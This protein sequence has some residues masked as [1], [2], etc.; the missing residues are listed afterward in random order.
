MLSFKTK[1]QSLH[2]GIQLGKRV[3]SNSMFFGLGPSLTEEQKELVQ[4]LLDPEVNVVVIPSVAG[5]GKTTLVTGAAKIMKKDLVY[6]FPNVS[7]DEFG[8]LPGP[9]WEKY[10]QYLGPLFDALDEIGEEPDKVVFN[11]D[12]CKDPAL[13]SKQMNALKNGQIWVYP[14][15]HGFLRGRNLKGDRVIFIDEAQNFSKGQLKKILTRCHDSCKVV[16]AGHMGQC[17]LDHVA[18]SG[19]PDYIEFYKTA[20]YAKVIELNKC[21]RGKVAADADRV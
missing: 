18:Q 5:T 13:Y 17:D 20:P 7:E 3:L 6:V 21:F 12:A 19:F 9:L 1:T 16:L 8:Y 15:P 14:K 4:A 2:G 10:Y 11:E